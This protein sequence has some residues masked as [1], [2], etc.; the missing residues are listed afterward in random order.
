MKA[1][2]KGWVLIPNWMIEE[3][4]PENAGNEEVRTTRSV[5]AFFNYEILPAHP[6]FELNFIEF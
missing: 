6:H 2:M 5:G 1:S 3:P 4:P